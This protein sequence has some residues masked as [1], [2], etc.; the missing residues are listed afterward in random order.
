MDTHMYIYVHTDTHKYIPTYKKTHIHKQIY[1]QTK[2]YRQRQN[3]Q[4][5]R[6][7]QECRKYMLEMDMTLN[8]RELPPYFSCLPHMYNIT[9]FIE[10]IETY[11][12]IHT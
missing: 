11:T 6:K 1:K 8:E 2:T 7:P 9:Q 3:K 4:R 10:N 5:V 12:Y